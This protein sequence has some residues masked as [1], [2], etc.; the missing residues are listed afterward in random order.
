MIKIVV[1]KA[2]FEYDIHSIVKAF[3]P[4]KDI[5]IDYDVDILETKSLPYQVK[6]RKK[7]LLEDKKIEYILEVYYYDKEKIIKINLKELSKEDKYTIYK[8]KEIS[9]KENNDISFTEEKDRPKIKNEL[10]KEIYF[11]LSILTKKTLPW[12]TLTGIRP[13]KI[14]LKK[15]LTQDKDFTY[16]YMKKTY[17]ASSEKIKLGMSIALREIEI[18]KNLNTRTKIL[19]DDI[20][21]KNEKEEIFKNKLG[22]SL[23]IGI[24]FC[25]TTC[26]YCSFPSYNMGVL[27]G[28]VE[29][30]LKALK[31]EIKEI[32][33]LFKDRILDTVYVGGGT[34]TSLNSKELED[35]FISLYDNFDMEN[36]KE[37]NVE[38]GRPDSIDRDKLSCMKKYKVSRISINPQTMNDKTLKI[39]GRDHSIEDV[40]KSFYMARSFG[41]DN[42]NMD[43]ILGLP[44]ESKKD[45][46]YTF[47]EIEKL[48]PDSLTIH[49]L[50]IK[51]NSRLYRQWNDYFCYTMENSMDIMKESMDLAKRINL[52]PYYLYRQ[53]N[54]A[55]NL[56]NVG[57]A[58]VGKEGL[59]NILIMEEEQDIVALGA[60]TASK[61]I[62]MDESTKRCEN[63]RDIKTYIDRIDE[64]IL[65]KKQLFF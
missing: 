29:P 56:E 31:R 59:Y 36:I 53:K 9:F 28:E 4:N 35:L 18:L 45:I 12:G 7:V 43:L 17:L 14:I 15:L 33:Y 19:E 8:S 47:K 63:V 54:I 55:G 46:M 25:P 3:F 65:R 57:Y 42:I 41:F 24:P 1:N 21:L 27:K 11:I 52:L 20:N 61:H 51:T 64:M 39:I 5:F 30:Y 22:Y 48:S 2:R 6:N 60:G 38:A 44:G 13:T 50:A 26:L 37:F 32:G 49:S 58:K 34:P 62:F 23:Y 10:K 40:Y 16:E